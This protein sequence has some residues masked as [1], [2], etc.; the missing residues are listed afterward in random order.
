MTMSFGS[1]IAVML[2]VLDGVVIPS[3]LVEPIL[4]SIL[5]ANYKVYLRFIFICLLQ[6]QDISFHSPSFY[7]MLYIFNFSKKL[8]SF[9]LYETTSF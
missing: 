4:R 9:V 6:V 8:Q 5:Y 1:Q 7:F 3:T 2:I